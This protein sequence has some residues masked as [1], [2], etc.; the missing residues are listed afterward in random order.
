MYWY[1][2]ARL[3][4]NLTYYSSVFCSFLLLSIHWAQKAHYLGVCVCFAMLCILL[5]IDRNSSRLYVM[6]LSKETHQ[7]TLLNLLLQN[8]EF[9]NKTINWQSALIVTLNDQCQIWNMPFNETRRK[10]GIQNIANTCYSMRTQRMEMAKTLKEK[11]RKHK[12]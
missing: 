4:P 6:I 12:E 3:L 10:I 5:Q 9:V 2:K 11:E 8:G 7:L 1:L